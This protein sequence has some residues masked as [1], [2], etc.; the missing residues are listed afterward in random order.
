MSLNDKQKRFCQEYIIDLNATQA[1]IRAGYSEHTA[2]SQGQRLLTHVDV[3]AQIAKAKAKR[4]QRTEVTQDR[5]IAELAKIGFS[6]IRGLLDES[7]NMKAPTEWDDQTAGSISSFEMMSGENG[8]ALHKVKTWDKVSALEKLLKHV[9]GEPDADDA[10][11]LNINITSA[12]PVS[13]VRVT[14]SDSK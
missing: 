8:A 4:E 14:R 3:Q 12:A 5:V 6:D 9:T 11:T 7:G 13:D 10:P 2:K 1:A